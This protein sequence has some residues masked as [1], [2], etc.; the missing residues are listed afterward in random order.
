[1]NKTTRSKELGFDFDRDPMVGCV[2]TLTW[3]ASMNT[4]SD[5]DLIADPD[6][7]VQN[8]FVGQRVK[9][10]R[11]IYE[12][13]ER[14]PDRHAVLEVWAEMGDEGT[15]VHVQKGYLPTV[16]FERTGT[17]TIVAGGDE[18]VAIS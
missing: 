11:Q 17:A 12:V 2:R 3:R 16:R 18:V 4:N 9:A 10:I 7:F 15:V 8:A 5:R 14:G 13:Q 6:E 1:M